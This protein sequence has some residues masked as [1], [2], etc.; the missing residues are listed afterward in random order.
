MFELDGDLARVTQ[1]CGVPI[2]PDEIEIA[3]EDLS[4]S[5]DADQ[6][7]DGVMGIAFGPET[8]IGG[9][10][11][12]MMM[13]ITLDPETG[14]NLSWGIV[15]IRMAGYYN[16]TES[17]PVPSYWK[18]SIVGLSRWYDHWE[19]R[20]RIDGCLLGRMD[21]T[22]WS[23]H[24]LEGTMKGVYLGFRH[25]GDFSG[26]VF[27]GDTIGNYN[28]GLWQAVMGGAGIETGGHFTDPDDAISYLSGVTGISIIERDLF[29]PIVLSGS[30]ADGGLAGA[31]DMSSYV[32]PS[33]ALDGLFSPVG[34]WAATAQ[35]TYE[36]VLPEEMQLGF[37]G[38]SLRDGSI[39]GSI[40]GA[41][42]LTRWSHG[43]YDGNLDGTVSGI[44]LL[45]DDN[46]T[47][48]ADTL[49]GGAAGSYIDVDED[50]VGTFAAAAGGEWVEV[51]Q[52]L[53]TT[54]M[55]TLNNSIMTLAN[56]V[57]VPIT[58]VYSSIGMAGG[59]PGGPITNIGMDMNFYAL[60][61][62]ALDGIWAAIIQGTYSA[63]PSPGWSAAVSGNGD[64]A[65]LSGTSWA[66]NQW[67]ANVAGATH[68]GI[69][70]NGAAT[71]TYTNPAEAET[72]GTFKGVGTGNWTKNPD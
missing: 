49:E 23:N 2:T 59:V 35:G 41:M 8:N 24:S 55:E 1:I 60:N 45:L 40:L 58:E 18:M 56:S 9:A 65:T 68:T 11:E 43:D 3:P 32:I 22:T 57:N 21:T 28:D 13:S 67:S 52:L 10:H 47:L 48:S 72:G 37:S 25:D 53:D 31:M 46:G 16:E 4:S 71:G 70:F 38:L 5:I 19:E 27:E 61:Q 17:Y 29:G 26:A 54:S 69:S 42:D 14:E 6:N 34:I 20:E 39:D 50:G 33:P 62:A 15:G 36:G 66:N 64:N 51:E 7:F 12:G 30:F 44:R 63:A